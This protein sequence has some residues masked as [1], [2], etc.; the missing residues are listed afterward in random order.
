VAP[1]GFPPEALPMALIRPLSGSGATAV[2]SETMKTSGPDSF[3]GY[4][5]SVI[6]GGTETTFYVLALYFGAVQVRV[7]RHTLPACVA[8]DFVG[9]AVA[10][11]ACRLFFGS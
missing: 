5:V 4:L 9:P 2:M 7:L 1:L 11:L 6:N 10:L 3:L 8:A